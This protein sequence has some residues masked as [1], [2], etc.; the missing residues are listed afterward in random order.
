MKYQSHEKRPQYLANRVPQPF[1]AYQSILIY[2][3]TQ[4]INKGL[5]LV[6]AYQGIVEKPFFS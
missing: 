4:A 1:K 6:Y 3:T 5:A 2:Y